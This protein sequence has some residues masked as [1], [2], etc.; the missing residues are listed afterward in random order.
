[1]S[2]GPLGAKTENISEKQPLAKK[3]KKYYG[4][5]QFIHLSGV[6]ARTVD[7]IKWSPQQLKQHRRSLQFRGYATIHRR[8]EFAWLRC[9]RYC[10]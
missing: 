8:I 9:S 2:S 10:R 4:R 5:Q 6:D 3:R 1:M 7:K